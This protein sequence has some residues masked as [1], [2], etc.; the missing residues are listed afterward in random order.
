MNANHLDAKFSLTQNE[1]SKTCRVQ[2]H[3]DVFA[4]A[5]GAQNN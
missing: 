3:K 1:Y 4:R 2:S 5:K